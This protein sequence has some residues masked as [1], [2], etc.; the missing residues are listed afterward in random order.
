[1]HAR[2]SERGAALVEMAF[3]LP[4]LVIL[5]LGMVSGGIA[6]NH[7]LA[8]THSAR[9]AGRYAATLPVTNFASMN[10]WLDEIAARAEEDATGSLD[11]GAPGRVVCVAY[12]HPNGALATDSTSNRIDNL[13]TVSY[14]AAPCFADGRP[15]SERRVQVRV[16]RETVFNLAFYSTTLTLDSEAVNRFEAGLGL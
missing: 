14:A 6:Y 1:M 16:A 15:D 11:P 7:Q 3:A 10:G 2:G 9:E 4:L 13:G 8:L 5:I 12:V